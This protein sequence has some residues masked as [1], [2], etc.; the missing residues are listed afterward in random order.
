VL[1]MQTNVIK[2]VVKKDKRTKNLCKRLS[3]HD[4][5]L[6]VH[7]NLDAVA[8]QELI[9]KKVKAVLNV[10][11]SFNGDYPVLGAQILINEGI[12][13]LDNLGMELFNLIEEGI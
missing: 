3:P 4:I 7:E 1:Q 6:V 11:N 9:E 2:G 12:L 8:A 13:L 5:A 10:C